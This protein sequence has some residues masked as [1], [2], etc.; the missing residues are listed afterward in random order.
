MPK[1][2]EPWQRWA[3][4]VRESPTNVRF[5]PFFNNNINWTITYHHDADVSLV[6]GF[7]VPEGKYDQGP[8]FLPDNQRKNLQH[9][10][11][12]SSDEE[13]SSILV[14][15]T[16]TALWIVSNCGVSE[17][18]DYVSE[19]R[20]KG[21]KV[22]IFGRCGQRDPCKRNQSCVNEL[23]ASTNSI[24]RSRTVTARITYLKSCGKLCME[25]CCPLK[26]DLRLKITTNYF[27]LIHFYTL[28]ILQMLI[29]LLSTYSFWI[30]TTVL[31][32]GTTTGGNDTKLCHYWVTHQIM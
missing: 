30:G 13:L 10:R 23:F 5:H 26:W 9:S 14:K 1:W 2:R 18:N 31:M 16:H 27:P 21:I 7:C 17:R 4:Q 22:D 8:F 32:N 20:K 3:L 28:R 15:K 29:I 25:I 19:M 11:L 12:L 6:W 24:L